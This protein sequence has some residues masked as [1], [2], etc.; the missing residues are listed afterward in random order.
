MLPPGTSCG[1]EI[2]FHVSGIVQDADVQV[3]VVDLGPHAHLFKAAVAPRP[4][5][6]LRHSSADAPTVKARQLVKEQRPFPVRPIHL[7]GFLAIRTPDGARAVW[8]GCTIF[9][10]ASDDVRTRTVHGSAFKVDSAGVYRKKLW[11]YGML[12]TAS[13]VGCVASSCRGHG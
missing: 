11:I 7:R 3:A 4:H 1:Q 2:S 10:Q 12:R 13:T 9:V 6:V 8:C 5:L